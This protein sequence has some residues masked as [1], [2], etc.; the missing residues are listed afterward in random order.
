MD[1]LQD[2]F[3]G[4]SG[5]PVIF[6]ADGAHRQGFSPQAIKLAEQMAAFSNDVMVIA[7]GV[8]EKNSSAQQPEQGGQEKATLVMQKATIA[9]ENYT[10]LNSFFNAASQR[11]SEEAATPDTGVSKTN[12]SSAL[13]VFE[14]PATVCG[15]FLT[16]RPS[17]AAPWVQFT[18]NNPWNTLYQWGYHPTRR[19]RIIRRALSLVFA[20]LQ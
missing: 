3:T 19:E 10:E 9:L 12:Q 17:R 8:S 1:R 4:G 11:Q 15:S 16:P 13:F 14:T 6:D 20:K 5:V 7:N 18:S 2:F